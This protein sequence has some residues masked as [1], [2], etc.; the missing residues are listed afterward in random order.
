MPTFKRILR[1]ALMSGTIVAM[2]SVALAQT[3]GTR[4]GED[5]GELYLQA[6]ERELGASS[7]AAQAVGAGP[8][9]TAIYNLLRD[10]G[11]LSQVPVRGRDSG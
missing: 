9:S 11:K 4:Q 10:K 1:Y 6:K 8:T 5:F 7:R 3:P 2:G